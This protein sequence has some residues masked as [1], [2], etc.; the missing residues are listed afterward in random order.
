MG[1]SV[2]W[3]IDWS[4]SN[5]LISGSYASKNLIPRLAKLDGI[6]KKRVQELDEEI[7]QNFMILMIITS[8]M[9]VILVMTVHGCYLACKK[10]VDDALP[11]AKPVASRVPIIRLNTEAPRPVEIPRPIEMEL[12]NQITSPTWVDSPYKC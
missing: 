4:N 1:A 10:R 6:L 3:E 2:H 8:M 12:K 5:N 7:D 11:I 9:A